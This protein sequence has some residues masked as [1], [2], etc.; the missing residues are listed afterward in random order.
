M[1]IHGI[2]TALLENYSTPNYSTLPRVVNKHYIFR[3][4]IIFIMAI[5]RIKGVDTTTGQEML[6]STADG[7]TGGFGRF[8]TATDA[9]SSGDFSAGLT[10]HLQ[11]AISLLMMAHAGRSG[12][13]ALITYL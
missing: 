13:L 2:L 11:L 5:L 12:M 1:L 9:T 4:D 10:G 8:G 7:L 6:A 3:F